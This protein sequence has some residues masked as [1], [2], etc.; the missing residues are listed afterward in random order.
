MI[1]SNPQCVTSPRGS[2]ITVI[3]AGNALGN[4]SPPYYVFPGA[5]WSDSLLTGAS[6]GAAG[7]MSKSGWSSSEAFQNYLTRNFAQYAR[8]TRGTTEP[9]LVLFD[10]H[11][12]HIS[13]TLTEWA[14]A[15]N[16]ILFVLPPHTSH[17]T[18][19]LDVGVFGP[20]KAMYNKECQTYMKNN[21]GLTITKYQVAELTSRPYMKSLT[22]EN[23][24]AA[25]C[26]TGI[27]PF[28]SQVI[29]DS[30]VAPA[31]IYQSANRTA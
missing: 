14:K 28:D 13:L 18:Q 12:S 26:K 25:F 19:T 4:S 10:R 21:P 9:T 5:R 8:I 23:L 16:V 15:H 3:A 31:V 6:T 30:Q 17:L 20:F 11:R 22:P 27:Y 7:I 24:T 29:S 2:T 1:N